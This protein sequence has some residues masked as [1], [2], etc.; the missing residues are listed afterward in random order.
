MLLCVWGSSRVSIVS[1]GIKSHCTFYI[2]IF[3]KYVIFH[4]SHTYV[5]IIPCFI[6]CYSSFVNS[7]CIFLIFVYFSSFNLYCTMPCLFMLLQHKHFSN[8]LSS[9]PSVQLTNLTIIY[10]SRGGTLWANS[11]V[12]TA[13]LF[14]V[15][16]P[17]SSVST[18]YVAFTPKR[19]LSA[20]NYF[21]PFLAPAERWYYPGEK[22]GP[23]FWLAGRIANHTPWNSEHFFFCSGHCICWQ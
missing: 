7:T 2:Y 16:F 11:R 15:L 23:H 8:F 12:H 4:Q 3:S 14:P 21:L 1:F 18:P 20:G 13:G 22:K 19:V 5:Y 10:F 17:F 9:N 6:S